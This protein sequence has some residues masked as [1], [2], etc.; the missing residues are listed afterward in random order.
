[1]SK[2]L[3]LPK[4]KI[5]KTRGAVRK[6]FPMRRLLKI[7][8]VAG[9]LNPFLVEEESKLEERIVIKDQDVPSDWRTIVKPLGLPVQCVREYQI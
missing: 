2:R 5:P 6:G 8:G 4:A 3:K 9:D 1:M 7:M